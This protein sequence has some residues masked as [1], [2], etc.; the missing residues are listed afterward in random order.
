ME[1]IHFKSWPDFEVPYEDSLEAYQS[2]INEQASF[3]QSSYADLI[4]N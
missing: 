3:I 2:I 1:H 4:K